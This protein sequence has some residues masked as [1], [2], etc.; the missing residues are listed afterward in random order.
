MVCLGVLFG[1][2]HSRSITDYVLSALVII[3]IL[4]CLRIFC[5]TIY[6][7]LKKDDLQDHGMEMQQERTRYV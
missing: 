4:F 6:R 5:Y 2:K 3:A 1:C 7:L